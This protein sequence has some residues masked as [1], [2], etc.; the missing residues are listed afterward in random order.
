MESRGI[1]PAACC[2]CSP[3]SRYARSPRMG[4]SPSV[5]TENSRPRPYDTEGVAETVI[6][7][8]RGSGSTVLPDPSQLARPATTTT[9]A[10]RPPR[11]RWGP[12]VRCDV[13]SEL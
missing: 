5:D 10:T 9:N 7:S 2:R 1:G 13:I 11:H 12:R 8:L 3:E 6:V 4:Y